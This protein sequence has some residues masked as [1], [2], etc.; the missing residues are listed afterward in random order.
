MVYIH[1]SIGK[2]SNKNKINVR[3]VR[4]EGKS[5]K[6]LCHFGNY[7]QLQKNWGKK[8][9]VSCRV[10]LNICRVILGNVG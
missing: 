9:K 5:K 8:Q 10:I 6:W 2:G 1:I 4:I 7:Q 3:N